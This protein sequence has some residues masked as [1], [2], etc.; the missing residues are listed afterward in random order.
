AYGCAALVHGVRAAGAVPLLC[1]I[2]PSGVA[3]DPAD[4]GRRAAAPPRAIVLVHPFGLPARL[5]GLRPF[6]APIVEDCAQ[7]LGAADRGR[8]V[9]SRGD[10]A[11]FS[12]APAK[13]VT[14]GG[15]GGGLAAPQASVVRQARDLATHDERDEDRVRVNGLL[16][17]LRAAVLL[18][19]LERLREIA[20]RRAAIAARYD[21]AFET[22]GF[23]RPR[24]PEG[25]RPIRFRYLVRVKDAA[26][27]ITRLE[28][29]GIRARHPVFLPLNRLL[30]DPGTFPETER[31]HA[32]L[33]SLPL[34]PLLSDGEID[35]VIAGVGRCRP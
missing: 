35:R 20:A 7:A 24:A 29:E 22:F 1:D 13:I 3:I 26:R 33:V 28:A 23:E 32:E 31:A 11:V 34:S 15:P 25:T 4:L 19:Q 5:E 30:R 12:F 2:E 6:G 14:C 21:A 9:G 8:P 27:M 10:A 16:G 18:A 17:D